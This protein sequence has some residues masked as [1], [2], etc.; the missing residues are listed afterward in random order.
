MNTN[1]INEKKSPYDYYLAIQENFREMTDGNVSEKEAVSFIRTVLP[2]AEPCKNNPD[3]WFWMY[4]EPSHMPSDCRVAYVYETTYRITGIIIYALT[5]YES[6]KNIEGLKK[7]LNHVLKGCMGRNFIGHGFDGLRD[8]IVAMGIFA[9][10][11]INAFFDKYADEYAEFAEFFKGRLPLLED[12]ASEKV[13]G[14]WGE[15]YSAEA[16]ATLELLSKTYCPVRVFVYG[17]LMRGQAA[18]HYLADAEYVGDYTLD[19]YRM[20]D[21]GSFPAIKAEGKGTIYGE[22]YT[23]KEDMLPFMDRYEGEGYLYVRKEVCVKKKSESIFAYVYEYKD[24][25]EGRPVE[26]R[27][28]SMDKEYVWYACYGS[29]LSADRFRCYIEGGVCAENGRSYEGYEL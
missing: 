24:E 12:L 18:H 28:G 23:I 15:S 16:T 27:W 21:L 22:V 9:K 25:P 7:V 2:A 10:S 8:F 29:N 20:Y 3:L 14:D 6:V 17:T 4:E 5:K 11:N 19:G 1:F 13:I 26:G